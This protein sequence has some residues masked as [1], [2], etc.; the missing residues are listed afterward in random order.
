[1]LAEDGHFKECAEGKEEIE[2]PLLSERG[3]RGRKVN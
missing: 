1:M 2:E 3:R